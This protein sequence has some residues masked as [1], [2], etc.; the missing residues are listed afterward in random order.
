L[1]TFTGRRRHRAWHRRRVRS[2]HLKQTT[3]SR[4]GR[5]EAH[6]SLRRAKLPRGGLLNTWLCSR[7]S[8]HPTG[9]CESHNRRKRCSTTPTR[10]KDLQ[11]T[12]FSC[13][14]RPFPCLTWGTR[15]RAQHT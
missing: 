5:T 2:N 13:K 6:S 14:E 11:R 15:R 1:T 8:I 12:A 3:E 10:Q 9:S 4:S 7:S